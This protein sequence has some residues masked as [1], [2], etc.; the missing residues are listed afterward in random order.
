MDKLLILAYNEERYIND[1]VIGNINEFHEVIVVNDCSTDS[2]KE[3][4]NNLSKKY[5]NLTV[6][7][8]IKNIGAG[9]SMNKGIKKALESN[10][11][12][13]VKI[14]GDN[15]FRN[16][17]I[18]KVLKSATE[19]NS[20]FIKSDRFWNEGI[21]GKIPKIRY[22]GNAFASFLIKLVTSNSNINDPLNGFFVFSQKAVKNLIIPKMF[23]R[24]GYPFFINSFYY[25]FNIH[26]P[27]NIHQI[28]NKVTYEDEN[29][30]IK[31]LI[32][33]I[34]LMIFSKKFY[35]EM[36]RE[37]LKLSAFQMSGLL[38]IVSIIS[39]LVAIL[40]LARSVGARFFEVNANQSAWFIISILFIVFCI[41]LN[42]GSRSIVK[43]Y[44][45]NIFKYLEL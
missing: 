29:S 42:I 35:F 18:K 16:T 5:N 24:Y 7:D 23:Y 19:N 26:T 31:P 25:K 41:L 15:Q 34:K 6:V 28:K 1:T 37:K 10:F 32:M 45:K 9:A 11:N 13:L 43:G 4:L 12:F 27:I 2:T 40:S 21:E 38:D 30:Y 14:D 44:N 8:N 17:D 36:I 39:F 3:I 22:F 20:D 33:F